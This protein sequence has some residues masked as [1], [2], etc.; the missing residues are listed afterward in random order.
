MNPNYW[1][2]VEYDSAIKPGEMKEVVFWKRS[3][4]LFRGEDGK[5]RAVENRCAHR[6]LKL[7][8]GHVEGC[9]VV[10]AYHGWTYDG[11]GRVTDIPHELFGK[12]MPKFKIP[13]LPIKVRY[14][15]VWMFFGD[16]KRANDVPLPEIPE[17]EGPNAWTCVPVDFTLNAH[18]SMIIDN[19]SDFTHAYLHRKYK[20]FNGYAKLTRMETIGDHVHLSYDAEVGR[21]KISGLFVDRDAI[22]TNKMDLCYEYPYQWSNTDDH[23]KHYLFVL[24]I[25]ENTTRT[26]FLFYFKQFIVPFTKVKIPKRVMHPFMRIANELLVKPLLRQDAYAVEAEQ[27]G[28]NNYWDAPLAELNPVVK[29]FQ[30]VTIRKWEEYLDEKGVTQIS[31]KETTQVRA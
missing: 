20:P 27:D 7:T 28:Y 26:F 31:K 13:S 11:E 22:D 19:V 2:A 24:P 8:T 18:H 10:C 3:V 9:N 5:L 12:K 1:Y 21:G 23:I 4:A 14:G 15:L 16:E 29:L 25:D 17:L 6:Q 30:D